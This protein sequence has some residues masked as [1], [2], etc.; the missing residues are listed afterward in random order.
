MNSYICPKTVASAQRIDT[1]IFQ[2]PTTTPT[3][4]TQSHENTHTPTHYRWI[5]SAVCYHSSLFLSL[6]PSF[7]PP[8]SPRSASNKRTKS[9]PTACLRALRVVAFRLGHPLTPELTSRATRNTSEISGVGQGV[10]LSQ[11]ATY[12]ATA[13]VKLG[14]ILIQ[15]ITVQPLLLVFI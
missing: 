10:P 1:L 2:N 3:R 8:P 14:L 4:Q 6:A 12:L 9:H 11:D 15:L 5:F 7:P 13:R